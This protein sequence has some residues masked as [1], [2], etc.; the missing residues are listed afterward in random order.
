MA[1]FS[2]NTTI[3]YD[4]GRTFTSSDNH[5]I[6]ATDNIFLC[7]TISDIKI[8]NGT[9]SDKDRN[10]EIYENGIVVASKTAL[11]DGGFYTIL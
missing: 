3:I 5:A 11:K 10:A 9:L 4:D 2:D 6:E 1:C 7:K 8:E